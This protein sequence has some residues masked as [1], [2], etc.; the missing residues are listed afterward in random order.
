[1]LCGL[2]VLFVYWLFYFAYW[3]FV[4]STDVARGSEPAE[5]RASAQKGMIRRH[6]S[7]PTPMK[8]TPSTMNI[9]PTKGHFSMIFN[10]TRLISPTLADEKWLNFHS[11]PIKF[12]QLESVYFTS[13]IFL[14][15]KCTQWP[16]IYFFKL[17]YFFSNVPNV[18]N[19]L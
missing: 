6:K 9:S 5:G 14:I 15:S 8:S 1:V 7:T 18:P 19:D 17:T 3:L 4:S 13:S 10:D 2:I 16:F 11:Y 12:T